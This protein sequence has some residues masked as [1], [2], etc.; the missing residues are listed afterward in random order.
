MFETV[1]PKT[2]Y[3]SMASFEESLARM[4]AQACPTN[5]VERAPSKAVGA[6]LAEDLIAPISVPTFDNSA[7]DGFAFASADVAAASS[8]K[9][10]NLPVVGASI[11]GD[12]AGLSRL[13]PGLAA[14]IMTG[15]PVPEGADTILPV[16][17]ASWAHE[18]LTFYEAYPAGKHV[19]RIGEDVRAGA[20]LLKKGIRLEAQHI[21][22]LCALGLNRI[23]SYKTPRMAWIAT[24]QEISDDFD[25]PLSPGH[26]YNATG[27][28]GAVSAADMGLDVAATVTVRDTPQDFSG[29]LDDALDSKV[30]IIISTGGVSAGQYDFVKPVLEDMGA[31]ILVHKARIKPGKPVL[32]ARL[33]DGTYFFG[34]PG[35]P[36]ST[37]LALRAFVYPFVRALSGLPA[38]AHKTGRLLHA[39]KTSF[40]RTV[41]L[42][43]KADVDEKGTVILNPQSNQQS[44]QTLPFAGSNAWILAPEGVEMLEAGSLVQWLPLKPNIF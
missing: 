4:V 30:D 2:P 25:A 20:Q 19:R 10:V 6:V 34:L 29:A 17:F 9:P 31:Q 33:P 23:K 5:I 14:K 16:E 41:F 27:L 24:G 39:C 18:K 40:D 36:I 38:E 22:L 15:A 43:A 11:A 21:P 44:F 12:T 28:Y 32:F 35:N 13:Q 1:T 3:L 7:M 37:A 26:I 8:A 42:M